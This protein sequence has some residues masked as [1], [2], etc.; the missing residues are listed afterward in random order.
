MVMW[1]TAQAERAKSCDDSR[2]DCTV[3]NAVAAAPPGSLELDVA[4]AP[5]KEPVFTVVVLKSLP[6]FSRD[7]MR[8]SRETLKSRGRLTSEI[9]PFRKLVRG[10]APRS[11][12]LS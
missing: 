11:I 5:L 12:P 7:A 9:W 6:A 2:L 3:D 10:A 8:A 1:T 4:C